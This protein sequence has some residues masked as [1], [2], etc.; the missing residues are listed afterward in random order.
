MKLIVFFSVI[1]S[2]SAFLTRPPQVSCLKP[3]V[4]GPLFAEGIKEVE[5]DAEGR[6]TKSVDS[7]KVNLSTVRTGRANTAMLDL[8]K[9]EKLPFLRDKSVENQTH[10]ILFP[11]STIMELKHL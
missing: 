9:G 2:V 4:T 7:V 11:K 3:L 8:V 10:K 5:D 1:A 6:M